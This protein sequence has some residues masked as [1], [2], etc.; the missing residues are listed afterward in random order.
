M[1]N[2]EVKS[3]QKINSVAL[4]HFTRPDL[5]IRVKNCSRA[6][7]WKTSHL[8]NSYY[9]IVTYITFFSAVIIKIVLDRNCTL[10]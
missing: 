8:L 3:S 5:Q 1:A 10:Y 4:Y 7:A 6:T 9:V 2:P